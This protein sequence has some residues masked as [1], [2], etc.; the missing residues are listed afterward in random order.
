MHSP[1][2]NPMTYYAYA[3]GYYD[4]RVNGFTDDTFGDDFGSYL[5]ASYKAGYDKGVA[6]YCALEL[7]TVE[8]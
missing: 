5:V 7:D 8:G 3:R 2:N 1:V 6:D 4:G